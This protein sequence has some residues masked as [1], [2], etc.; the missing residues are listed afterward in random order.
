MRRR[1][2]IAIK[3]WPLLIVGCICVGCRC[4]D[5]WA[6]RSLHCVPNSADASGR[7]YWERCSQRNATP[8]SPKEPDS[9]NSKVQG[10]GQN[11]NQVEQAI[12]GCEAIVAADPIRLASFSQ[13]DAANDKPKQQDPLR[14]PAEFPGAET[15]PV[16]LPR[17]NP[18]GTKLDAKTQQENILRLFPVLPAL[19]YEPDALPD[20]S[21]SA[22]GLEEFHRI[23]RENHPG[24]RAAAASVEAAHG[25]V[26][27][28]GLP[29]NPNF[30]YEADTVRTANT[31]GYHGAYLQQT[32]ITA[33]KLGL[34]AQAATVDYANAQVNQRKAWV[35]VQST[36]RRAYFQLLAARRRLVL[37]KTQYEY[38]ERA[39][40][41]QIKKL[42]RNWSLK[43]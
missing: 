31:L 15:P 3:A 20:D 22:M 33:Q 5:W 38:S 13:S 30:G 9:Q 10:Q 12:E 34:A 24:L 41:T 39:Y 21:L 17:L 27:Q 28:A 6:Y 29:P 43:I 11:S 32:F 35:T 23:A 40:Q 37:A 8:S 2:R 14:L 25:Q 42:M 4:P 7:S 16:S 36:V 26:I 18:D 19:P 1:Q